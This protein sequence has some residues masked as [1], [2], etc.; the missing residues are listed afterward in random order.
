MLVIH[1]DIL[2]DKGLPKWAARRMS[3]IPDGVESID[4]FH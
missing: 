2:I 4:R 1:T 3:V